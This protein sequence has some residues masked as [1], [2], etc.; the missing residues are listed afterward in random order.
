MEKRTLSQAKELVNSSFPTIFSKEDVIN[1]LNS[2][3]EESKIDFDID[4]LARHITSEIEDNIEDMI[5][6]DDAKFDVN[7]SH[8]LQLEITI[9]GGITVETSEIRSLVKN[10]ITEFFDDLND[11]NDYTEESE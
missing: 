5:D 7:V 11:L 6:S 10:S 3:Q 2:I 4:R 8:D 9:G 1:L